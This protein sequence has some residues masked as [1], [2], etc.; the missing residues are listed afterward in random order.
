MRYEDQ[1]HKLVSELTQHGIVDQRVLDAFTKIPRELF[2]LP[3]YRQYAY[4]NKPLPIHLEQTISQ[5]LMI[6]IMFQYLDIG[7]NDLV[8]EIGT[9]SGYQSA[10]LAEL[11]KEVCSIERLEKLSL[12][13][14]KMI[15]KLGYSN[16]YFRIGDGAL[17]WQQAFPPHKEFDRIIVSAGAETIP[18]LLVKQL[19]DNGIMAIP[20][21]INAQQK[22]HILR[23]RQDEISIEVHDSCAF[24][25]LI[26]G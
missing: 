17:G 5:P 10:L 14:K 24:V 4:S 3:E 13:A 16:V 18:P 11:A 15:S 26:T 22:L 20:V 21:G 23:R 6:A 2:V 9:G 12:G 25:P 7:K 1:R 8:L 19:A